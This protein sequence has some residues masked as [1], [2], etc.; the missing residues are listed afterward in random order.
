MECRENF[1]Y[2][3]HQMLCV[4]ENLYCKTSPKLPITLGIV[5]HYT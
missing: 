1:T 2:T 4:V 5:L 3:T